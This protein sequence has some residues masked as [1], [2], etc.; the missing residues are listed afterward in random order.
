MKPT[1][2]PFA[3]A[4]FATILVSPLAQAVEYIYTNTT[5]NATGTATSW[6]AGPIGVLFRSA[7]PTPH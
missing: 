4:L 6:A 3:A 5:T 7:R 1:R 2:N